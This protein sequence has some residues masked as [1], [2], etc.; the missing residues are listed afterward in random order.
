MNQEPFARQRGRK[1]EREKGRE[2]RG[3]REE[4]RGEGEGERGGGERGEGEAQGIHIVSATSVRRH[5]PRA[6]Q[7]N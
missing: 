5:R 2:G 1:G 4:R 7:T 6:G 3:R